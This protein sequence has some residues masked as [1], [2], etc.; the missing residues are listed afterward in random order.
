MLQNADAQFGPGDRDAEVMQFRVTQDVEDTSSPVPATLRPLPATGTP[1]TT[2]TWIFDRNSTNWTI[3]DAIFDR[4]RVDAQPTLGTTERWVFRNPSPQPHVVHVHLND[5]KLVSRGPIGSP[6]PPPPHERLKESW[7]LDPGEEVVVDIPFSDYAGKFV[8]HCHVLEHEDD[9]MMT[10]F[11]TLPSPSAPHN[12]PP[13]TPAPGGGPPGGTGS[14]G[15]PADRLS[16]KIRI[17]SSRRLRRILRRGLSFGVAVPVNRATLRASLSVK[18]RRVASVRRTRL[19]RGRVRITL[20]LS[21]RAK[22]RLRRLLSVR[23]RV[24]AQF[25][26]TAGAETRRLR[27]TITR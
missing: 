2:R 20:K 10:Q 22:A 16:R 1:V 15:M 4:T 3:N 23:R 7:R 17:L 18:G 19:S 26:V 6:G 11:K 8:M 12:P 14:T 25:T 21:R 9:G 27:F 5:Q 13:A 24:G